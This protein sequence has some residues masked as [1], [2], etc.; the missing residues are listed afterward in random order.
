MF[1]KLKWVNTVTAHYE[2]ESFLYCDYFPHTVEDQ[3]YM[4]FVNWYAMHVTSYDPTADLPTLSN[5]WR[6]E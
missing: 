3:T 6:C 1:E 2:L 4:Q 5:N